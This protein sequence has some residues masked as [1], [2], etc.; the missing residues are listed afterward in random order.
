M[1][2]EV[3][4]LYGHSRLSLF[5]LCCCWVLGHPTARADIFRWDTGELIPGTE[6]I[7]PGPGV[8][9]AVWR[10]DDHNL[11]YADFSGG[12]NLESADFR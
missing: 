7:E 2:I 1:S 12:L 8:D 5:V 10:T 11:R 3:S 9:L 4:A 6:G